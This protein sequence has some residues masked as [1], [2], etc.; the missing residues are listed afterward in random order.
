MRRGT[1]QELSAFVLHV[2]CIVACVSGDRMDHIVAIKPAGLWHAAAVVLEKPIFSRYS[3]LIV[4]WPFSCT[5]VVV[6]L[7]TTLCVFL[8]SR[9]SVGVN[10]Q[11]VRSD[12]AKTEVAGFQEHASR[13]SA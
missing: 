12:A 6:A 7:P 13:E 3:F 10:C 8:I 9:Q 4:P 11:T 2:S 5:T 1:E